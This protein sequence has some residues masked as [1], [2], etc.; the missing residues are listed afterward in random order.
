MSDRARAVQVAAVADRL[1]GVMRLLRATSSRAEVAGLSNARYELLH[2]LVHGGPMRMGAVARDVGI[3][4]R[5]VTPMVDAL[6]A[7]GLLRRDADPTDR[8]AYLLT[9][10]KAGQ[11]LMR[12]AHFERIAAASGIFASLSAA[13]RTALAALLDKVLAEGSRDHPP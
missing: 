7:E 6:E 2:A 12:R 10:T 13:E 11:A 3:S 5:T 9:L 4:P 8:R 1:I